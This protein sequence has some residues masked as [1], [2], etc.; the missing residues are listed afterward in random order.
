MFWYVNIVDRC[1]VKIYSMETICRAVDHLES[2]T[3]LY[4]EVYQKRPMHQVTK[5]LEQYFTYILNNH[6]E[7]TGG[8]RKLHFWTLITLCLYKYYTNLIRIIKTRRKMHRVCSMHDIRT[9]SSIFVKKPK[10][11]TQL[12][13]PR[14]KQNSYGSGLLASQ[15]Q[16]HGF[17]YYTLTLNITELVT[18]TGWYHMKR[19]KNCDYFPPTFLSS[20]FAT[21]PGHLNLLN[22]ICLWYFGISTNYEAPHRANLSIPLRSKYSPYN[23]VLKHQQSML[24]P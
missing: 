17:S 14:H 11:M 15:G 8:C 1:R 7:V 9:A 13:R 2:C 21:C 24:F 12:W 6:K 22:L 5:W 10:G 23:P 3:L 4:C 16:F 20:L 18:V 19:P